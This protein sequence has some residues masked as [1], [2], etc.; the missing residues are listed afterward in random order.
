[1]HLH[2]HTCTPLFCILGTVGR[3]ALKVGKFVVSDQLV[4]L[5][6]FLCLSIHL[7]LF[8]AQKAPY[9]FHEC[10]LHV[11][12]FE[13]ARAFTYRD[14]S[15]LKDAITFMTPCIYACTYGFHKYLAI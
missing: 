7:R 13:D 15:V 1:M 3:T 12:K 5:Y 11:L 8:I 4:Q 2:V 14:T 10:V 9:W 6:I